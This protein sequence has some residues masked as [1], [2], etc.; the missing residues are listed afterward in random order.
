MM[1]LWLQA[2]VALEIQK[3]ATLIA[4][5][6]LEAK[7]SADIVVAFCGA[8]AFA[9]SVNI[10]AKHY[11]LMDKSTRRRTFKFKTILSEFQ[12]IQKNENK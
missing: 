12:I 8:L 3:N 11:L 4:N 5:M 7:E 10:I 2:L 6:C 1:Y 9:F